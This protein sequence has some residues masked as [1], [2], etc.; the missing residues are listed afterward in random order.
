[1]LCYGTVFDV[2]NIHMLSVEMQHIHIHNIY[3]PDYSIGTT[4]VCLFLV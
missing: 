1:M 2:Y 4:F 3:G